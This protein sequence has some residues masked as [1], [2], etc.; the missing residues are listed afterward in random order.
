M[1]I[2]TQL[3]GGQT[4]K[5]IEMAVDAV[6]RRDWHGFYDALPSDAQESILNFFV[7]LL[8]KKGVKS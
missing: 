2:L 1:N 6:R 3:F 7:G 5:Q 8:Q 4:A